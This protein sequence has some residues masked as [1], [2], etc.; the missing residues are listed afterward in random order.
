MNTQYADTLRGD[1]MIMSVSASINLDLCQGSSCPH[2][3]PRVSSSLI[4][5]VRLHWKL[6][7]VKGHDNRGG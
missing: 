2:H 5:F 1:D 7:Q 4:D 6:E 3:R